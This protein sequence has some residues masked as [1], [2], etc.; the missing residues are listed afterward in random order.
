MKVILANGAS[1]HPSLVNHAPASLMSSYLLEE[2]MRVTI[3]YCKDLGYD[4]ASKIN[5]MKQ[6]HT[7]AKSYNL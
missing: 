6:S 7:D 1:W 2:K 5:I 3:D 4:E